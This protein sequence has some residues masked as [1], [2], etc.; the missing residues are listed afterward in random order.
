MTKCQDVRYHTPASV[1]HTSKCTTGIPTVVTIHF[2]IAN[3]VRKGRDEE[4]NP[5]KHHEPGGTGDNS[6]GMGGSN[7]SSSN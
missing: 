3:K 7:T 4:I 6:S 1:P 2:E 5:Q